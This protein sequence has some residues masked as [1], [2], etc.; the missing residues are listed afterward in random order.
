[1]RKKIFISMGLSTLSS[2]VMI[3]ILPVIFLSYVSVT[4]TPT[5][6]IAVIILIGIIWAINYG[7]AFWLANKITESVN[8]IDFNNPDS[9]EAYDE[10]ASFIRTT[11]NHQSQTENQINELSERIEIIRSIFENM[12]EGFIMLDS[13]ANIV[14]ANSRARKIFD[15][16]E[17]CEGNDIKTL[18]RNME[19][20]DKVRAALRRNNVQMFMEMEQVYQIFFIPS[21]DR[22]AVI[23]IYDITERRLAKKMRREFLPVVSRELNTPLTYIAGLAEIISKGQIETGNLLHFAEK[24]KSEAEGMTVLVEN[25]VFLSDLDEMDEEEDFKKFDA[26]DVAAEVVEAMGPMAETAQVELSLVD[27]PSFIYGNR[28]LIYGMLANL[29]S[30][31]IRYNK[32][33]GQVKIAVSFKERSAYISVSDTGIGI[34][35]EEQHRIFDRFYRIEDTNNEKVGG[36]GLGLAIVRH[37]VRY[38]GG[39]IELESAPDEGTRVFIKLPQDY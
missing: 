39:T 16:K 23:L 6:V 10:L 33:M 18:T 20:L 31:G 28:R 8:G 12:Q 27:S 13:S 2:L 22:G 1:M 3:I 37:I 24:I 26:S 36:A 21:E 32:P 5:L 35:K 4:I 14:A 34:P 30:N 19:F 15:V 11:L 9:I 38:H 17:D 25:I 29:V 7:M